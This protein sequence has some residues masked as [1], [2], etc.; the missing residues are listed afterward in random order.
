[1]WRA[2]PKFIHLREA[3]EALTQTRRQHEALME[4]RRLSP[5]VQTATRQAWNARKGWDEEKLQHLLPAEA[6][7]Y[8]AHLDK[9][10]LQTIRDHGLTPAIEAS[11]RVLKGAERKVATSTRA[12]QAAEKE[13]LKRI[14]EA[15]R[16]AATRRA[17]A[18][19]MRVGAQEG[20]RAVED[21]TRRALL[22]RGRAAQSA[23]ALEEVPENFGSRALR[24]WA[25]PHF[26][27]DSF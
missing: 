16:V 15:E 5:E 8:L 2:N 10:A 25:A 13:A 12:A 26:G 4:L 6:R 27:D 1:E 17:E 23:A 11:R 3:R 9:T 24:K 19:A 18:E 22:A 20:R 14:Q 7:A 21:A